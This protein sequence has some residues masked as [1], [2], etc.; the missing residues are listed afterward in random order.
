VKT[1]P[2][3]EL[4][5]GDKESNAIISGLREPAETVIAHFKSWRISHTG[6][7]RPDRTY[8]ETYDAARGLFFFSNTPGF[9]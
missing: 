8:R 2:G 6:Y 5:K 4:S 7:R 3:G 9:E 1:P